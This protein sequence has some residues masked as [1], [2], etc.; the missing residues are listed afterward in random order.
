M[1]VV[2]GNPLK[3][4]LIAAGA[5]PEKASAF[6]SQFA[7]QQKA[8][9][10]PA[11]DLEDAFNEQLA[12]LSQQFFP[13]VFRPPTIDDPRFD[14]YAEF[15]LGPQA[16]ATIAQAQTKAAP[17]ITS[18]YNSLVSGGFYKED[19]TFDQTKFDQL[20]LPQYIV[21]RLYVDNDIS[22]LALGSE[23]KQ[24]K[25]VPALATTEYTTA[26]AEPTDFNNLINTITTEADKIETESTAARQN[27][28]SK[29][30]IWSAGIP[31]KN[32]KYG[33]KTDLKKGMIDYRTIPGVPEYFVAENQI[34]RERFPSSSAAAGIAVQRIEKLIGEKGLSP[35][36][37]EVDRRL[38]LK[39]KK[40]K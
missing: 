16:R 12:A 32:L 29:D 40:P 20:S 8:G 18:I 35:F 30:K 22:S 6:V 3:K 19:G 33:Y 31:S 1:A 26:F 23:I 15:V 39:N 34:A 27:L 4:R 37:D 38:Y 21:K 36:K 17:N 25:G 10:R 2:G 11:V 28:L 13:N 9:G 5:S 14:D 7:A 24:N